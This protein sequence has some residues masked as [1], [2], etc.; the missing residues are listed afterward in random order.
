[1]KPARI[2]TN[3]MKIIFR[4]LTALFLILLIS[5]ITVHIKF[6]GRGW[7]TYFPYLLFLLVFTL[8]RKTTWF[9]GYLYSIYGLY[10]YF[11]ISNAYPTNTEFT[12]P[13]VELLFG[14]GTGFSTSSPLVP[15]LFMIPFVFYLAYSLTYST[16]CAIKLYSLLLEFKKQKM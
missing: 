2:K 9:L 10:Y 4:F 15:S 7:S 6:E 12:L 1:M 11:L 14:D 3:G 13:L 8:K 16:S 5:K